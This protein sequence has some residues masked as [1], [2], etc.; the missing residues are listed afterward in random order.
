MALKERIHNS[1]R[2]IKE[3]LHL[4]GDDV[5]KDIPKETLD[6]L[7]KIPSGKFDMILGSS[8]FSVEQKTELERRYFERY[9][10]E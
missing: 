5:L 10:R 8:K 9:K 3:V 4:P 2:W 1:A 6:E 7:L